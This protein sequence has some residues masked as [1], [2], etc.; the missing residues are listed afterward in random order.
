MDFIG[1]DPV[2]GDPARPLLV[3]LHGYGADERDLPP[4]LAH[5]PGGVDWVSLRA[6]LALPQGGWAWVP[7]GAVPAT[8]DPTLLA[9]AVDGLLAWLD[10][11]APTRPLIPLGFSQGGLMTTELLRARP[12][13][14]AAAVVLS[15]FV[16][17]RADDTDLAPSAARPPAF[18]GWGTADPI[19]PASATRRASA[20]LAARTRLDEHAYPGLPH[21]ISA[22]ELADIA[23]FLDGAVAAR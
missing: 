17:P 12:E 8:P 5:L 3:L 7:L 6:P 11:H 21:A 19:I 10:A 22:Q 14:I 9:Q 20:W 18:F 13:R 23:S 1:S 15:G 4:I 2:L 16:A